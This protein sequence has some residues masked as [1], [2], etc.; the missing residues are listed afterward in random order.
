MGRALGGAL[1]ALEIFTRAEQPSAAATRENYP[2][3][4]TLWNTHATILCYNHTP[5]P[6]QILFRA[7]AN[8]DIGTGHVMRCFALAQAA[9]RQ[10]IQPTFVLAFDTPLTERLK[11]NG[12]EVIRIDEKRASDGDAGKVRE[13]ASNIGTEWV[14]I[15]GYDF[16]SAY[17]KQIREAGLKLFV[18]DDHS[19]LP[20]YDCD[21]L[22]NQNICADEGMYEGK[23]D[24][25]LLLGTRYALLRDEFLNFKKPERQIPEVAEKVLM[26]FGGSDIE[27]ATSL[28]LRA[29]REVTDVRLD[30]QV[31]IGSENPHREEIEKLV[32]DLPHQVELYEN[33][34]DMPERMAWADLAIAAS[35]STSW[36]LLY[37]GCPIITGILA[38]NQ[39][40]IAEM[41]GKRGLAR[42][43]G[44][45]EDVSEQDLASCISEIVSSKELR[46]G[47]SELG[48]K[49]VDGEG[50]GRVLGEMMGIM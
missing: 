36:E 32:K 26:T 8:T 1:C 15:D 30:L 35:G 46:Q 21:I 24:A 48:Q 42:N 31:I 13:L 33:V 28:T 3:A 29:L 45:Y 37:M 10:G 12:V 16:A 41:L 17:Q 39:A 38:E 43:I 14:C 44:W 6:S 27:N 22:F 11:S 9:K 23:T 19:H 4:A 34:A 40:E 47:M 18:V 25:K 49:E 50:A 7:D 20:D 2:A 5:M